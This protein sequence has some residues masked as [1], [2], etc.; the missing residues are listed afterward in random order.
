M[1]MHRALLPRWR[2]G[3][4]PLV[5][6]PLTHPVGDPLT[7]DIQERGQLVIVVVDGE[8]DVGTAPGL[9]AELTPLADAGRDLILDLGGV[10]FCDCVGLSL[11]LRVHKH[12]AAAG[13]SLQLT[14]ATQPVRRLITMARLSDVLPVTA[15]TADAIAALDQAASSTDPAPGRDSQHP[16]SSSAPSP[17]G[18]PPGNPRPL[19]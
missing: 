12:A 14:A 13:G 2:D 16:A 9:A 19:R 5:R 10:Q 11:F 18:S 17:T 1:K 4:R 6:W 8:L 15:S 3:D 7:W